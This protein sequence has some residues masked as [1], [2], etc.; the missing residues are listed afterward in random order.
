M[1]QRSPQVQTLCK[2]SRGLPAILL[3]AASGCS[4]EASPELSATTDLYALVETV[5]GAHFY[6]PLGPTPVFSGVFRP[7]LT[8]RLAIELVATPASGEAEVVARFDG[9]STPRLVELGLHEIYLVDVPAAAYFTN[10]AL[11]YRFR[12]MYGTYE[13]GFSDLSG[14]VFEVLTVLPNLRVGV[15]VRVEQQAVDRDGDGLLD[16]DDLCPTV[17]DPSNTPPGD[18]LCDGRDNNCDGTV[19]EGACNRGDGSAPE[20]AARSCSHIFQGGYATG[21]GYYWIDLDGEGGELE[22]EAHY[23]DMTLDG[24][25]FV[26]VARASDTNGAGGDYEFSAAF[27]ARSLLGLGFSG[28][29]AEDPQ[30]TRDLAP[31]L[32]PG[33]HSVDLQYVCY[34][35]RSPATTRYWSVARGL[36]A[37]DLRSRLSAPNPDFLL[38]SVPIENADGVAFTGSYAFFA[39]EIVGGTVS[40]GNTFAGQS[41]MK[42]SCGQSGQG[43]MSPRGVWMLTHYA[44]YNYTE[45]TSC[46]GVAGNVLPHYAGEVRIRVHSCDDALMSGGESD[47][48]CGG[49]CA[50][51]AVG[52][53]C[54]TDDDC[55]SFACES[56]LCAPPSCEDGRRNGGEV[57]VDCGGPCDDHCERR[58]CATILG[59]GLSVGSGEYWVDGDGLGPAL[60]VRADCDMETD[61]GGWTLVG[62]ASDT[63]GA[64]GDYELGAALGA[65]SILGTTFSGGQPSDPQYILALGTAIPVGASQVELQYSCYDRRDRAGTYYWTKGTGLPVGELLASLSPDNPD[66]LRSGVRLVNMDGDVTPSGYFAV[67]GREQAGSISCG[68]TH[69]GQSG[70]KASCSQGGQGVLSPRSVWLLT[71]YSGFNYSEVTSC[72]P[73]AG[74]VLPYFSGEVRFREQNCTDGIQAGGETGVD[75]GGACAGCA[76]GG[77]CGVASDCA[78]RV[79]EAGVCQAPTCADGV[80]NGDE[81][82]IDCGGG[83]STD[84]PALT[85]ATLL[86]SGRSHGSGEYDVDPDGAGPGGTLRVYCDMETDGGGWTLVARASDTNGAGGDYELRAAFGAVGMLNRTFS[87]GAPGSAQYILGLDS[88]IPAASSSFDLQFYCYDARNPAA[89]RFW[90]TAR[91]LSRGDFLSRVGVANPDFLLTGVRVDNADGVSSTTANLAVLGREQAGS[92]SCGNTHAGQLGIK[93]SC[94]Q[95]GQTVMSPRGVWFLTHYLS[96]GYSEVTSCGGAAGSVLPYYVGEIRFR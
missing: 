9:A 49:R 25:G 7:A 28:G 42:P 85:C 67:F 83:C 29:T 73:R 48:D 52:R 84:C 22:P 41:G 86:S 8:D 68:N 66:L 30:Y 72:G 10:P 65:H 24:G 54:N 23:C 35:R 78:S 77:A 44:G 17:A 18:E 38:T 96:Y 61:G 19:D 37:G 43:V 2:A 88:A 36:E 59:S 62:R 58:S 92:T 4:G 80:A 95:G 64:G 55:E 76:D 71:H 32:G 14:R 15:K 94:S 60:P 82:S 89:T 46:G 20:H 27:G 90:A 81:T 16:P 5:P 31:L 74:S 63:N 21:D 26:L 40:C 70:F 87:G 33:A 57:S 3:A 91:G 51:C 69:A 79:C 13:L 93:Y 6:P 50:D 34:D 11:S 45:V 12:V 1:L 39:R 53:T 75:C 47:V 56:G